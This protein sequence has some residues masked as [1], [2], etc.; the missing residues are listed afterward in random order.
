M[1]SRTV[2]ISGVGIAGPTLAWWLQHYGFAPTLVERAPTLRL[3][4][5]MIDFWGIGFDVAQRMGLV[6][7][8]RR[9][10][11]AIEQLRLVD[12]DSAQIAAIDVSELRSALGDRLVSLLR[13]DLANQVYA[14][15]EGRVETLFG[16]SI[17][18]IDDIGDSLFVRFERSPARAFDLVVGA[19][20]LH[21]NV[22]SLVFG[23][24]WKLAKHLG[25]QVAVFT[26]S[27]YPHRE[28]RS[29]VC[30]NT[31]GRQ[32][33]RY[34]LRDGRSAFF[35]IL[36]A[37][38]VCRPADEA[39]QRAVLEEMYRDEGWECSQ[40]LDAMRRADDLYFD[41]ASQ[42]R[43]GHWSQGRV[44]LIGDACFCPS[45]LAGQ[46]AALAMGA[47]YI[48][49]GELKACGGDH[50]PAFH[51]YQERLSQFIGSKQQAAEKFGLWFAPATQ[52]GLFVRNQLTRLAS[53]PL[54]AR[55]MGS[56]MLADHFDLPQY[57]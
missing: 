27:E 47:A 32:I 30:Y 15:L 43:M 40:I 25:Y 23:P 5:Y 12:R 57:C 37:P 53:W 2:L 45:L 20:G 35:F 56:W 33:A 19:D 51:Q 18:G 55:W 48:L 52:P 17:V 3:G 16:D 21:S 31:P 49:A 6:P 22:R 39:G 54:L 13:S 46:G 26:T 8:L 14:S 4:G 24:E 1:K 38:P 10:G 41:D 29:Y 42:I 34:A 9:H 28:E 7:A 11:Y 44:A 50:A 36:I